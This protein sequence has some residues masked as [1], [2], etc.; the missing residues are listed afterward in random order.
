MKIILFISILFISDLL[1]FN[2]DVKIQNIQN[3]NADI[4]IAL[5][6]NK[7]VF[8][9]TNKAYK[10]LK[11]DAKNTKNIVFYNIPKG[12]YAISLY[13]DK[14]MNAKLDTNFFGIPNEGIGISNNSPNTYGPPS[15]NDAKFLLD[16][17]ITQT[18]KLRY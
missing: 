11:I 3:K 1:S 6:N 9:Q 13:E 5:Y 14:N 2:I 15:W 10:K 7:N 12:I 4:Y 17:S 18:I 16:K 8:L